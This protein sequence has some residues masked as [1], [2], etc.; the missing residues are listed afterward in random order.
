M[1]QNVHYRHEWC[2]KND[3]DCEDAHD[4]NEDEDLMK[5]EASDKLVFVSCSDKW[6]LEMQVKR[7]KK[8][9]EEFLD[10]IE[11]L[12]GFNKF[13]HSSSFDLS[14]ALFVD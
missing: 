8:M 6:M 7:T 4:V 3:V 14:T 1:C 12:I 5:H 13:E 2:G 11:K 10:S 9:K